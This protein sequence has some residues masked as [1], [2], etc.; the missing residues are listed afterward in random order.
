MIW[1]T[2]TPTFIDNTAQL[3][4]DL[5]PQ[6][7]LSLDSLDSLDTLY[8]L[9]PTQSLVDPLAQLDP[10]NS[11]DS[12]VQ[13]SNIEIKQHPVTA[14][15]SIDISTNQPDDHNMDNLFSFPSS[16]IS[17]FGPISDIHES[18]NLHP[19]ENPAPTISNHNPHIDVSNNTTPPST[20]GSS[21]SSSTYASSIS[22]FDDNTL[23]C[24]DNYTI[25]PNVLYISDYDQTYKAAS[26]FGKIDKF[27]ISFDNTNLH[28]DNIINSPVLKSQNTSSNGIDDYTEIS[29]PQTTIATAAATATTATSIICPINATTI[30]SGNSQYSSDIDDDFVRIN[31]KKLSDSRL[32]LTQLSIVLN[33]EGNDNETATREKN[34]LN[35]LRNDINFPI[36]EKTW[37]RDTPPN[38]RERILTELTMQVENQFHY[39]YSKKILA[40]IVRRAS[41]YMMQGRLR[42][43][44]RLKR[45]KS[46]L[47]QQENANAKAD[48]EAQAQVQAQSHLQPTLTS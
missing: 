38:E 46:L 20:T 23:H 43:Q 9:D 27:N 36:G 7:T 31:N 37:I 29:Y 26:E 45:K 35:I 25:Q 24:F 17:D 18:L 48:T 16:G 15:A 4:T 19:I 10:I 5:V 13:S 32:S 42:R 28:I 2:T 33:L 12:L 8:T 44:R 6:L 34:I 30:I 14:N 22:P 3:D 39:G 47:A 21:S 1:V 40:I 41:Y 11:L